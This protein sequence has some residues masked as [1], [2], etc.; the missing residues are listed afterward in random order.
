[1]S[2]IARSRCVKWWEKYMFYGFTC[3]RVYVVLMALGLVGS[4]WWWCGIRG[5]SVVLHISG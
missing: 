5:G 1:M 3:M 4:L 2:P